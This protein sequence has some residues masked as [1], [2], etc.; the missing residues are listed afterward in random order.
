MSPTGAEPQQSWLDGQ[1]GVS[2]PLRGPGAGVAQCS[3]AGPASST[4]FPHCSSSSRGARSREPRG[5]PVLA[6]PKKALRPSWAPA[7]LS[8]CSPLV[9]KPKASLVLA[10]RRIPTEAPRLSS[11][12][13]LGDAGP[14]W[15]RRPMG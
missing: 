11:R 9:S 3:D 12:V 7:A 4:Q 15:K 8:L 5:Q 14:F 2:L 13:T 1:W 10:P 6:S